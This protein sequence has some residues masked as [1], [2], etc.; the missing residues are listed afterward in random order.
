MNPRT[1]TER[2]AEVGNLHA[3]VLTPEGPSKGVVVL[4]HGACTSG[5]LWSA[6]AERLAHR[7]MEVWCPDL[8]GHGESAGRE[9]LDQARIEDY[10]ADVLSVLGASGGQA[11]VGHDMGGV[12]AQVVASRVALRGLVLVN[13]V[14]PKGI[15]GTGSVLDIWRQVFRTRILT[16]ILKGATWSYTAS[17]IASLSSSKLS[18]DECAAIAAWLGPESAT[19]TRE[20]ALNGI[21]VEERKVSCATFV[22]SSTFDSLTPPSRQRLIASRYRA[23]YVEFAQHAH[24]PMLEPGWERPVAVI[25]RWLEE[26]ARLNGDNRGSISRLTAA[27]RSANGTPIPGATG[28]PL[29]EGGPEGNSSPI[30][31]DATPLP[32]DRGNPALPHRGTEPEPA[33]SARRQRKLR[34]S[35]SEFRV[36]HRALG[37]LDEEAPARVLGVVDDSNVVARAQALAGQGRAQDRGLDHG[38]GGEDLEPDQVVV[39]L[40]SGGLHLGDDGEA[41]L[42]FMVEPLALAVFFLLQPSE[43]RE[44]AEGHGDEGKG[45]GAIARH[46]E[47]PHPQE[48]HQQGHGPGVRAGGGNREPDA[49]TELGGQRGARAHRACT[50]R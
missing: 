45:E 25:G 13:S 17:E 49:P 23:D 10:V 27:R 9:R 26:A 20:M 31:A 14:A 15:G 41:F 33:R 16:A 40:L 43:R 8:R 3:R 11:V 12:V 39:A 24:F 38:A 30:P 21:P 37:A 35:C 7:G 6:W 29:P 50:L 42:A 36:Q 47:G 32:E 2:V 22:V 5:R 44:H 46:P 18:K 19:A 1:I 4:V 34:G 48:H 28:T